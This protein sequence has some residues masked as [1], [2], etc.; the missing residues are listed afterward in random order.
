MHNSVRQFVK[1]VR[2]E[3]PR[4][5]RLRK[6]LEV[7]SRQI[8]GTI[9]DLFWLCDYTGLDIMKGKGV[10]VVCPVDYYTSKSGFEVVI[11]CEMLEH[12]ETWERDLRAMYDLLAPGGLLIL[13]CAAPHRA[14]HGTKRTT[15]ECSPAT[16]DYYRN[17]SVED[18]QSVLPPGLFDPYVLQYSRGMSDLQFYGIKWHPNSRQIYEG[19][20]KLETK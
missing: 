10:D 19:L 15:P 9:R 11:S 18:F 17:I 7:G 4:K 2:K 14:E 12:S 13:T 8:N 5:F 20:M 16:T 6:V 3:Y 1:D